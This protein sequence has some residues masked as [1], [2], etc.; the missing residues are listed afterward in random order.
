[1]GT[2]VHTYDPAASVWIIVSK[3]FCDPAVVAGTVV[4]MRCNALS[5]GTTIEYDIRLGSDN[6]TTTILE[7]DIFAD[8][9]TAIA[10]YE[11]RL[12]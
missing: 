10:E 5:T 9:T 7:T 2:I 6:G 8:L 3:G 4:Q 1:M 12:S 11:I